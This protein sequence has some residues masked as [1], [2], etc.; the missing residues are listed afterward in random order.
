MAEKC[1]HLVGIE[2]EKFETFLIHEGETPL[3]YDDVEWFSFCPY[4]GKKLEREKKYD[5]VVANSLM[6]NGCI[7]SI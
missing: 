1:N 5:D 2:F 7:R 6:D 4:C 3:E